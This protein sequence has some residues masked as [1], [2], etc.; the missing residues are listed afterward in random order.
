[1]VLCFFLQTFWKTFDPILIKG[2]VRILNAS[3]FGEKNKLVSFNKKNQYSCIFSPTSNSL[4][5]PCNSSCIVRLI[6]ERFRGE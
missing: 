3:M 2:Q 1:M 4:H 6:I 5:R